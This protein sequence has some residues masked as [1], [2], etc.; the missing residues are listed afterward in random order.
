MS[1]K[2]IF[3]SSLIS[4]LLVWAIGYHFKDLTNCIIESL[5][6]PFMSIDLDNNGEPDLLQIKNMTITINNII[7]PIG[8]LLTGIF[9]FMFKLLLIFG[10]LSI[11]I[12]NTTLIKL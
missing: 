4:A 6:H 1:N 5:I 8:K 11:I 9:D 2:S 7:F 12:K 3:I 10:I